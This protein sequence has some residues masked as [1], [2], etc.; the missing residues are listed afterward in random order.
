MNHTTLDLNAHVLMVIGIPPY[1]ALM[2]QINGVKVVCE[3]VKTEV[4]GMWEDLKIIVHKAIGE[5]VEASGSINT[6]LLD[7]GSVT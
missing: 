1:V 3:E 5:K 7:K 2:R 6:S 4:R